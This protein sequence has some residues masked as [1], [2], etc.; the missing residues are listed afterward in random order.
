MGQLKG[1]SASCQQPSGLS[2]YGRFDFAY[3]A[4]L[5]R[6]LS[7]AGGS[8][9]TSATV[10]AVPRVA[11]HR[12]YNAAIAS[13]FYTASAAERDYVLA[14]LPTFAYEG[15]AFYAYDRQVAG[16][17]PVFRLY[18]RLDHRHFYTVSAD[19]RSSVLATF[20]QFTDEGT[21]WHAQ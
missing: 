13:H 4:A 14:T 18:S 15:V 16:S 10:P 11:V 6:W 20:P 19:E 21:A 2:A 7:P 12:F 3:S 1:G 17:S 8:A 5:S 9:G